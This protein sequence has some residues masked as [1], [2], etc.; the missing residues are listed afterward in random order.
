MSN[1]EVSY[2]AFVR[3]WQ[4]GIIISVTDTKASRMNNLHYRL[5]FDLEQ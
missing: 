2:I 4:P 5:I 3:L 1:K